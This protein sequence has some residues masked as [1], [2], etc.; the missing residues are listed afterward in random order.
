M[1]ALF[2]RAA[3]HAHQFIQ[4]LPHG[5]ETPIGEMGHYLSVSEKFRIALA[6]AVLRDPALL[7]IEEP[8][9]PLDDESKDLIDDAFARILPG[10]TVLFLPHRISTIRSCDCLY[11]LHRGRVAASGTHKEVLGSNPLYRHLHYLEFNEFEE[12]AAGAETPREAV[13][14]K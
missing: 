11:L 10:R 12:Q 5:Y 8:T 9:T 2:L 1:K 14:R 7:I 3:C 4:K 13:M 6:R